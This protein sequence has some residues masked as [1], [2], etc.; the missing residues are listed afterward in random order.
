MKNI[1]KKW[2]GLDTL[3]HRIN[4]LE[5]LIIDDKARANGFAILKPHLQAKDLN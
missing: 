4:T 2:L 1:L 3:E 5:H